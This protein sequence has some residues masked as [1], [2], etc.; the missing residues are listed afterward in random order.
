[1][2]LP[3]VSYQ[4]NDV[5]VILGAETE[6]QEIVMSKVRPYI[7]Y[8]Q[9]DRKHESSAWTILTGSYQL[10]LNK[11]IHLKEVFYDTEMEPRCRYL[12]NGEKKIIMIDQPDDVRWVAQHALRLIRVLLRLMCYQS[13]IIYMHGGMMELNEKGIV[14]IGGSR[15]GKTSTILSL[16]A[17][18]DARY[19]TNDDIGIEHKNEAYFGT[20]WPRSMSIRKDSFDAIESLGSKYRL[21]SSLHPY[22]QENKQYHFVYPEELEKWFLRP[23]KTDGRVHAIVFPTF[24]PY[25]KTGA[26]LERITQAEAAERLKQHAVINPGRH[27]EFLLPFFSLPEKE[28]MVP[29]FEKL[30]QRIPCYSLKQ[31]FSSLEKGT[32]LISELFERSDIVV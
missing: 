20:G 31:S 5:N 32:A 29:F 14:F 7:Q 22:N 11:E 25:E 4:K 9:T 17:L 15:A 26:T 12:Y 23:I 28:S 16:L 19:I 21:S 18:T 10:Q 3:Y 1:M 27:N 30:S 6:V 2:S 13:G 24:L 8:R